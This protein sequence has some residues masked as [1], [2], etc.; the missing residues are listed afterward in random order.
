MRSNGSRGCP[1]SSSSSA[2]HSS[3]L[4]KSTSTWS[5]RSGSSR[6]N[7]APEASVHRPS[8]PARSRTGAPE[9]RRPED[10]RH[11]AQ[12][13]GRRLR[14]RPASRGPAG[15]SP[16]WRTP[17]RRDA[18]PQTSKAAREVEDRGAAERSRHPHGRLLEAQRRHGGAQVVRHPQGHAPLNTRVRAWTPG[19]AASVRALGR[20]E[21]RRGD[22]VAPCR[23]PATSPRCSGLALVADRGQRVHDATLGLATPGRRIDASASDLAGGCGTR[24]GRWRRCP[25]SVTTCASL[26]T[27]P[28]VR[29][30][31]WPVPA[32]SRWRPSGRW[33]TGWGSPWR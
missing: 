29:P 10:R 24:A 4:A 7:P 15:W 30:R 18:A 22:P 19:C 5:A 6:T 23:S 33:R 20:H 28:A 9:V 17:A 32:A 3:R 16:A 1:T 8:G 12:G 26:S 14:E 31:G 2:R 27:A 13:R 11:R 25:S 21:G